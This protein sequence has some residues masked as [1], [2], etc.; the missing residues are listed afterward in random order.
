[1]LYNST[2]LGLQLF[3]GEQADPQL[4]LSEC[5]NCCIFSKKMCQS[6]FSLNKFLSKMSFSKKRPVPVKGLS[7]ELE[8]EPPMYLVKGWAMSL[9]HFLEI[10][11]HSSVDRLHMESFRCSWI[12]L[13][14]LPRLSF[15]WQT[16]VS[17]YRQGCGSGSNRTDPDPTK[18]CNKTKKNLI[19]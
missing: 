15:L 5:K 4:V 11:M 1:M 13:G 16:Q 19:N 14:S 12:H 18:K 7:H 6:A 8:P 10:C 9:S 17:G 3:N 2:H